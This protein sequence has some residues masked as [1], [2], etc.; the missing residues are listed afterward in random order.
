[1]APLFLFSFANVVGLGIIVPLLPFY[2]GAAG[3]GPHE[4]AWLFAA[5]SLA[6]FL[7]APLWGRLSD[8]IGRKPVIL[9]SFA[10]GALGYV[11][12][13]FADSLTAIFLARIFGGAMNGWLGTTQ[14]YIADVTTPQ[15]RARGMG[16]LGAAFGVGFVVGPA[17][18]GYLV[19]SGDPD[20]RLPMLLAAAGSGLA[21]LVALVA[22]R[23]PE[24]IRQSAAAREGLGDL[25]RLAPMV[26]GIIGFGFLLSFVFSGMES[27]YALWAETV[28]DLGPR[29]V[30][31][32]LAFAGLCAAVVQGGLVGWL[33]RRVGEPSVATSGFLVLATGLV[34]LTQAT[35]PSM[36][37]PATGLLG[38]GF[39]LAHPSL[40]SL[41]SRAAASDIRGGAMGLMQS[42]ASL[43]RVLGPAWAGF[44]FGSIGSAWPFLSGAMLLVPVTVAFILLAR[45]LPRHS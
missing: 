12:L 37:I 18:G 16:V 41:A 11:W 31:Y 19:G 15:E 13:V 4:V 20:Y 36:M 24:R 3:A 17:L 21:L 40:L 33:V 23:E 7:T 22:M 25:L 44:A 42:G 1:M 38:T 34:W 26:V 10:G 27:T 30:G 28:F 9:L 14:A 5:Y 32:Y 43:G 2:A 29:T 45:H 8:R 6:Q 35:E 39:G